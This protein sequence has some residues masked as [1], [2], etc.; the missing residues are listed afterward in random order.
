M[1]IK[2]SIP[3]IFEDVK[4]RSEILHIKNRKHFCKKNKLLMY[5]TELLSERISEINMHFRLGIEI[6]SKSD[7]YID[8]I[9]KNKNIGD[10]VSTSSFAKHF[11]NPLKIISH[12]E[13]IPIKSNSFDLCYSIFGLD[14]VNDLA[15][16]LKQIHSL[17]NKNGMFI[18]AFIGEGSL[19][20]LSQAFASV[21][22]KFFG[23]SHP[24][25]HPFFEIKSLAGLFQR[26]GF[27]EIVADQNIVNNKYMDL[28]ELLKDIRSFGTTN[29]LIERRKKF[30]PSVIFKMLE[31]KLQNTSKN[32][33]G[34]LIPC[35]IIFI[36][37]WKSN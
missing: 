17:L 35:N 29:L 3:H 11:N 24:R 6:N 23:G 9:K 5:T 27:I 22:E 34:F 15:G 16:T 4:K 37:C 10:I 2:N 33:L 12:E 32:N 36:T 31:N 1:N 20:P 30:T 21:D 25:I 28:K 7:D 26:I 18:A 8:T 14:H 19:A 13:L